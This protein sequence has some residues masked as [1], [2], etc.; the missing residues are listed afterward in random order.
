MQAVEIPGE[1]Q[2]EFYR[3]NSFN[4]IFRLAL[5]QAVILVVSLF[6]LE[7]ICIRLDSIGLPVSLKSSSIMTFEATHLITMQELLWP[8]LPIAVIAT[9]IATYLYVRIFAPPSSE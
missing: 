2:A 5:F 3:K 9:V 1:N 6:F 4:L 8:Y 7:F